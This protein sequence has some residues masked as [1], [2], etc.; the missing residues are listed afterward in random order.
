MESRTK[1]L[2]WSHSDINKAQYTDL[3]LKY[4]GPIQVVHLNAHVD[5]LDSSVIDGYGNDVGS[6]RE[7]ANQVEVIVLD[8]PEPPIGVTFLGKELLTSSN[9]DGFM[10]YVPHG[11][12]CEVKPPAAESFYEKTWKFIINNWK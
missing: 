12:E 3:R 9:V 10:D 4:G 8:Y 11:S 1:I 2:W 6:F 5:D 7:L